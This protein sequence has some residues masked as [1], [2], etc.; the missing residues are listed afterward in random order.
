M[1]DF[2]S[3][4]SCTLDLDPRC[5]VVTG[6]RL[7]AEAIFR[8]ITTRRGSLIKS[9]NYGI[10]VSDY[11]NSDMS[12]RDVA[13]MRAAI[14]SECEKDERV[15][16]VEVGVQIPFRGIGVYTVSIAIDD[17]DGPFSLTIA[18]S[19]VTVELLSIA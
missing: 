8:R 15:D 16:S 5:S 17:G 9:P 18:V 12:P 4:L 11:M 19:E 2:G 13:A 1:V 10:D 7:L 14:K 6:R 3:D